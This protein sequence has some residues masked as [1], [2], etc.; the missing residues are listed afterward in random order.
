MLDEKDNITLL[1]IYYMLKLQEGGFMDNIPYNLS[2]KG[3]D[4]AM[5]FQCK[6]SKI[7]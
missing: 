4:R 3:F 6:T 2:P 7:S 1:I 5:E